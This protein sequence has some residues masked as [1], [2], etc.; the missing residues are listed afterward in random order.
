[1]KKQ[2]GFTKRILRNNAYAVKLAME[3]SKK[4]VLFGLIKRL[5]EYLLWVFYSAFFVRFILDAIEQRKPLRQILSAILVIGGVSLILQLFLYY[6]G[7]IL[8]PAWNVK[9][10]QQLYNRI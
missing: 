7:N 6:C 3:I 2:K 4:R 10:F 1:M 5:I 8:F 9:I